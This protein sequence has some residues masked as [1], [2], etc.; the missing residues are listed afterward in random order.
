[1]YLNTT[2]EMQ[3]NFEHIISRLG[4]EDLTLIQMRANAEKAKVQM[5]NMK[6]TEFEMSA[7][8][9]E[10]NAS[11]M[12]PL[13]ADARTHFLHDRVV[14]NL[15]NADLDNVINM[16]AVTRMDKVLKELAEAIEGAVSP[17][18]L[19]TA[20]WHSLK[21]T[22]GTS[23]FKMTLAQMLNF[24]R[25]LM[26]IS[27]QV[28]GHVLEA[29]M[30]LLPLYW[31]IAVEI[32]FTPL[33]IPF[34]AK[35]WKH[36][37]KGTGQMT[38]LDMFTFMGSV[39]STSLYKLFNHNKRPFNAKDIAV[40][41][42][43]QDPEL[44]LYTWNHDPMTYAM[45]SPQLQRHRLGMY[46]WIP[47][48]TMTLLGTIQTLAFDINIYRSG[49][50]ISNPGVGTRFTQAF[51]AIASILGRIQG[52][53]FTQ[54]E[55]NDPDVIMKSK[56]NPDQRFLGFWTFWIIE[57]VVKFARPFMGPMFNQFPGVRFKML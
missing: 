12:D 21:F 24:A 39:Y 8:T 11:V 33:P 14:N 41:S 54:L 3:T 51:S 31:N 49:G 6:T 27:S 23:L 42:K 20:H 10:F 52:Y 15:E 44:L 45:D 56:L 26:V 19:R 48:M 34:L 46:A 9:Q 4:G 25:S 38:F 37:T 47:T 1:M 55:T 13:E 57:D 2:D 36:V 18:I 22:K 29:I 28:V 32:M 5:K 16:H 30:K 50:S 35:F 53:P 40:I 7:N 43:V 17:D